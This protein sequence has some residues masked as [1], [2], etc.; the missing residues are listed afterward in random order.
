[1]KIFQTKSKI[2][3]RLASFGFTLVETLMATTVGAIMLS[4]HYLAFASGFAMVTV[5]R[6]DLR[7][8]QIMLKRMEAIRLSGFSQLTDPAKYPTNAT[9]YYDEKDK[10]NGNGGV[11]YTVT[12]SAAAAPTTLPP[13]YRTNV[14]EVRVGVSWASGNVLRTR[15]M[16]TFVAR[17]GVQSYIS[18]N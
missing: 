10:T 1:M 8:S 18:G 3:A 12:Y 16:R 17:S 11:A 13:T 5:T 2:R 14:L 15:E 4:A 6:E 9:E 7:A